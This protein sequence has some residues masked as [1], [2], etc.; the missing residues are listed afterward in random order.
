MGYGICTVNCPGLRIEITPA[1]AHMHLLLLFKAGKVPSNTVGDPGA[2]GATV[3]G[4]QGMG[5]RTPRAAAVAAATVGLAMDVHIPKGRMLTIGAKSIMLAASGPPAIVGGPLG[6]TIN[7]LGATPKEHCNVAPITTC[8]PIVNY[9]R[10]WW[11]GKPH[12]YGWLDLAYPL[13]PN[14]SIDFH[15][16]PLDFRHAAALNI[17]HRPLHLGR[18]GRFYRHLHPANLNA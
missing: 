5:V 1:Q 16:A 15:D 14:S 10:F 13:S 9:P 7:A 18:S 12:P 8:M 17:H 6:I 4:M 3:T 2:Q 11:A